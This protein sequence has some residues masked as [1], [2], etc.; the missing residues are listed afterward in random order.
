MELKL[1]GTTKRQFFR[2]V[3]VGVTAVIIDLA[4]YLLLSLIV[5]KNV[6]KG[7]SF[8]I[9]SC[10]AYLLNRYWTFEEKNF[11]NHNC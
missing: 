10:V 6:A 1:K 2:F 11:S 9:G 8:L 5:D 4:T 7:V 3:I